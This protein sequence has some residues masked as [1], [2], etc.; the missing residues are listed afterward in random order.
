MIAA[1][2]VQRGGIYYGRPDVDPWDVR[3]DATRYEGPHPVIAHPPCARWCRLAGLVEARTG[4]R[5][6]DDGGTF[7]LALAAVRRW[8]GVLEHPAWSA[9]WGRHGLARPPKEG[10]QGDLFGGFVC[11]VEQGHYGHPARKAT[12]LYV[13]GVRDLPSLR[14]GESEARTL[15]SWCGNKVALPSPK[16]RP[17]IGRAHRERPRG[18]YD[19]RPRLSKRRASATPPEFAE[20][21]IAM[22]RS[23][24]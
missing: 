10:W 4:K 15:V 6:G 3:R 13:V 18:G 1:L 24:E 9:A 2:Y 7:A 16:R 12:W 11:A 14:W 5:R 8:G 22:A 23:A 20:L 21:L 19:E 17:M